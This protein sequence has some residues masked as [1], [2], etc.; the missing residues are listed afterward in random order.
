M[1]AI[2]CMLQVIWRSHMD[3]YEL[4]GHLIHHTNVKLTN[5]IM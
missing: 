5:Y 2:A 3:L 1:Y 4:T